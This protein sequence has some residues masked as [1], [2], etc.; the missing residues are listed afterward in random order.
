[1]S[2]N[3]VPS[4]DS[5]ICSDLFK[6]ALEKAAEKGYQVTESNQEVCELAMDAII[7]A[8][9]PNVVH[10][11]C[12]DIM[13]VENETAV[14]ISIAAGVTLDE[15]QSSLPGRRVVR[16]MPNTPCQVGEGA[17]CYSLGALAT[18]KD[19]EVVEVLFGAVGLIREVPEHLINAVTGL[20]GSGPA[21][22]FMF[23]EALA[24][25]G[26]RAGLSRADALKLAA[27]TVKGAAEMV[28]TTGT[29]P[30]ELKDQV[31][32]PGGTTIAGCDELE[33]G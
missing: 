1:M 24:D 32:S 30:G 29:H 19:R 7:I 27:Q 18:A 21:Y 12:N 14:I 25:G 9:K 10:T 23:I 3:V 6:G 17:S 5:I 13:A 22:V 26:V 4:P 33:K 11:V 16:I 28:L 2:K 20:S 8:V 15:L 31:C